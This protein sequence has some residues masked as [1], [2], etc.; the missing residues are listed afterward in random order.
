MMLVSVETVR[1][2]LGFDDMVNINDAVT[3]ALHAVTPQIAAALNTDFNRGTMT[4]IFWVRE[5]TVE[6]G[7]HCQTEFRL[8]NGLLSAE[9]T[10]V[11]DSR[12]LA[13][14]LRS[15]LVKGVL[16]DRGTPFAN[17]YLEFTYTYGFLPDA[18]NAEMFDQVQVPDWLKEMAR[19]S[20]LRI[21]ASNPVITDVGA[22]ID[23]VTLTMQYE[24][25]VSRHRRYAPAALLPI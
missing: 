24:T 4:D 19:I 15:D 3:M 21:L 5:P 9:P 2:P 7:P 10:M 8:S 22:T 14:P 11:L 20:A 18:D 6:D 13:F 25:L 1:D 23:V 12:A 16:Y 17:D